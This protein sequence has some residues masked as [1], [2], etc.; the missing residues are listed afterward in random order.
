M[1]VTVQDLSMNDED[2][3]AE[4]ATRFART[5]AEEIRFG[6]NSGALTWGEA[7][8]LLARLQV[9]VDQALELSPLY[10]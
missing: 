10:G 7:D 2:F 5:V 1:G 6:V 4:W 3:R 9:V 8:Q